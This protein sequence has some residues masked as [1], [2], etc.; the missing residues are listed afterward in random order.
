MNI[1][2]TVVEKKQ[3]GYCI[4]QLPPEDLYGIWNIV[5]EG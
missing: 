4:R 3:L 2:L 5:Q 1:P